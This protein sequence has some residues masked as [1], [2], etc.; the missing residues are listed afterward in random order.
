MISLNRR[1]SACGHVGNSQELSIM[2]SQC[3][4][5][6]K[7]LCA[8]LVHISSRCGQLVVHRRPQALTLQAWC[9]VA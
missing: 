6:C 4:N 7:S 1:N 5:V 9:H 3:G 8:L 2:S